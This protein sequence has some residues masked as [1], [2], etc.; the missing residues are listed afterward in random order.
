MPLIKTFF[1]IGNRSAAI[2]QKLYCYS[3]GKAP[4]ILLNNCRRFWTI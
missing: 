1:M 2:T 3:T 4:H